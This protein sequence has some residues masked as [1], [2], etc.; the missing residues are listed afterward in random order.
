MVIP[1]LL[2]FPDSVIVEDIKD[3]LY[4]NTSGCRRKCG[5]A[6]SGRCPRRTAVHMLTTRSN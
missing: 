6:T 3:E 2:T 5:Q 4:L 1:N